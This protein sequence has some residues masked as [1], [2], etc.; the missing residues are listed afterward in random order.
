[1]KRTKGMCPVCND[2]LDEHTN[3]KLAECAIRLA[4]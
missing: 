4:G 2:M 1:M 3:Q